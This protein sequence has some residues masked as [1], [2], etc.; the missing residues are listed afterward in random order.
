M[1][2]S[3]VGLMDTHDTEGMAL[4]CRSCLYIGLDVIK[5]W[6]EASE[7]WSSINKW[8]KKGKS[9][10]DVKDKPNWSRIWEWNGIFIREL[11]DATEY[12]L[13]NSICPKAFDQWT[14]TSVLFKKSCKQKNRKSQIQWLKPQSRI[15][16]LKKKRNMYTG[17]GFGVQ[18]PLEVKA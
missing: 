12:V 18:G 2:D 3:A 17:K 13:R 1:G 14:V 11:E 4:I 5:T 9:Q 6:E 7:K 8:E 16:P 10:N 15:Y